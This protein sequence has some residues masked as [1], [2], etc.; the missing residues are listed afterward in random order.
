MVQT[1][2]ERVLR[3]PAETVMGVECTRATFLS[4]GEQD[5]AGFTADLGR[6]L[7]SSPSVD[8]IQETFLAMV[9]A[10]H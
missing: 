2:H 10:G 9:P 8:L 3:L 6:L 4:Y 1:S 7:E 5:Q